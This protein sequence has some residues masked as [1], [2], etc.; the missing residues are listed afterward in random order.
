MTCLCC[1]KALQLQEEGSCNAEAVQEPLVLQDT[2][3]GVGSQ[4]SGDTE[5]G[6]QVGAGNQG[7]CM[8]ELLALLALLA[9]LVL[10]A[11][12]AQEVVLLQCRVAGEEG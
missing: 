4:G 9:H 12:L 8:A 5:E 7:Q 3:S 1:G 6:S 2:G 11:L 10:L